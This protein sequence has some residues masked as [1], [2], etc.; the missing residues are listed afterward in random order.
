MSSSQSSSPLLT[1]EEAAQYLKVSKTSLRR[2]TNSG[3]LPCHRVGIRRERRFATAD[4][5]RCVE[6]PSDAPGFGEFKTSLGAGPAVAARAQTDLVHVCSHF[7]SVDEWWASFR[8]YLRE[9]LDQD[10]PILYIHD[11][12][13]RQEF[14]DRVSAEGYDAGTLV[15]RGMLRLVH[16][17]EAYLRTG[18]SPGSFSA[19]GMIAYLEALILEQ[20]ARNYRTVLLSGEMTWSLAGAPGSDE[21]YL[22]ERLLNDLLLKYP[23]VSAVCHYSTERFNSLQTLEA[24]CQHTIVQMPGRVAPGFYVRPHAVPTA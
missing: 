23:G 16:T 17:S 9:H 21:L 22:Y 12:T 20:R 6:S 13:S 1:I 11:T 18:P 24:L 2:W 3:R 5:D 7:S 10:A 4:L 8:P 19:I 14:I 15:E